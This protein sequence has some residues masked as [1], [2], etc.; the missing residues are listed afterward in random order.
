MVKVQDI[1]NFFSKQKK[2]DFKKIVIDGENKSD[3]EGHSGNGYV[4]VSKN[5]ALSLVDLHETM[6]E[7]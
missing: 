1:K 2:C 4:V 6:M 5:D 3:E 7:F